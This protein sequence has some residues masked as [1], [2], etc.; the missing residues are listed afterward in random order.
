VSQ[1]FPPHIHELADLPH[2]IFDAIRTAAIYLSFEELPD[3]EQPPRRIWRDPDKLS[4]HFDEV[5]RRRNQGPERD[6]ED[7]VENEAARHLITG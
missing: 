2:T 6:I 4:A 3:D 5:R 1:L 7:P